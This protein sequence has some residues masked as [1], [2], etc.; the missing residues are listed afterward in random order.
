MLIYI[1]G[2]DIMNR[3]IQEIEALL[4]D[5]DR[6]GNRQVAIHK[7]LWLINKEKESEKLRFEYYKEMK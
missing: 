5:A 7:V 3:L 2:G 1:F 4:Y 6:T